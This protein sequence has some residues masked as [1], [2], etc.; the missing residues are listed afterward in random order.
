MSGI[1]SKFTNQVKKQNNITHNEDKHQSIET[2]PAMRDDRIS[3]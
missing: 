3:R 2:E 1:Q